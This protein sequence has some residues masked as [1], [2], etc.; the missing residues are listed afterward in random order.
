MILRMDRLL[1][2]LPKP[3]APS[4]NDAA[5]VQELLGGKYG[6]MSTLLNYTFQSFNFRGRKELRPFYDLIANI[7]TEE[8][9]HIE[10]V[11]YTINM[12]LSGASTQG[13]DPTKAPLSS[14]KDARNSYHW[15]AAGQ[16]ALPMDSMGNWWNGSY[17]NSSGNLKQDLLFNF[18]LECGARANKIRAYESTKDPCARAMIGYLLVRGGVH[19]VAYARALEK[20]T[21]ADVGKLLPIPDISNKKFTEA[22]AHEAKGLHTKLYQFSPSDY[23]TAGKIWN[24][25]HPEDGQELVF[26]PLPEGYGAPVPD[27]EPEPQLNAP[28]DPDM[29]A[30]IAKRL[31]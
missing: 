6:E 19:I 4:P 7:A 15:I 29:L 16:T 23:S 10:L 17:V 5:A 28:M 20:L 13:A 14:I 9:G 22:K 26:E 11:S 25:P 18:N 1:I 31:G 30:D 2:D 3:K 21:G 12:L 8:Y 24:G 27:L